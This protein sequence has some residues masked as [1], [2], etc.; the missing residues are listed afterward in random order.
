MYAGNGLPGPLDPNPVDPGGTA[1]EAGAA[2]LT[3]L[4]HARLDALEI[5]SSYDAY[6]A[7]TH[8]WPYWARDLRDSMGQ[9]VYGF[10]LPPPA[11]ARVTYT[12]AEPSYAV[13]GWEVAI[14]RPAEEFSTL[15]EA[16]A[17]G[18]MLSG[19]G[20][21]SVITP[22]LYRPRARYSVAVAAVSG[23]L[24]VSEQADSAGRLRIALPLGPG[25]AFAQY[26]AQAALAGTKVFTTLVTI[27]GP[28]RKAGKPS[29]AAKRRRIARRRSKR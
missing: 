28:P 18:F 1:I 13:Y 15:S 14:R 8:S 22:A 23:A 26:T 3:A 16:A 17:A 24:T 19:S 12:S 29:K 4:F 7:G 9:I 27:A 11:P 10:A 21:A 5:P 2:Q 25:N 6:G 20:S